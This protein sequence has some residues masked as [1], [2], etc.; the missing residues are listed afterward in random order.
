M[1]VTDVCHMPPSKLATGQ[2]LSFASTLKSKLVHR[3][4]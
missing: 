3:S 4:K 1:D 2:I